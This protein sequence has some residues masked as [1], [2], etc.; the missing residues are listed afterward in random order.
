MDYPT[1]VLLLPARCAT[2]LA[3]VTGN[4]LPV[5][6]LSGPSGLGEPAV[7]CAACDDE[8]DEPDILCASCAEEMADIA[9]D[10]RLAKLEHELAATK[11]ELYNTQQLLVNARRVILDQSRKIQR[12]LPANPPDPTPESDVVRFIT[13]NPTDSLLRLAGQAHVE[14]LVKAGWQIHSM[15]TLPGDAGAIVVLLTNPGKVTAAPSR[16]A[17]APR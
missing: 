1:E 15:T 5:E 12:L 4:K 16:P 17:F 3:A 2:S 13:L 14:S 9:H 7:R 6:P 10:D 11:R 8:L